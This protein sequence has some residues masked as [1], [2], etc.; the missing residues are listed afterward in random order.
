MVL[1]SHIISMPKSQEQT[2][3]HQAII[4]FRINHSLYVPSFFNQLVIWPHKL[5]FCPIPISLSL[6]KGIDVPFGQPHVERFPFSSCLRIACHH[7]ILICFYPQIH[8]ALL[9]LWFSMCWCC[10]PQHSKISG[11]SITATSEVSVFTVGWASVGRG[12]GVLKTYVHVLRPNI[13]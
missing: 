8:C 13:S 6:L 11:I 9:C 4:S 7:L 1:C 3:L 10:I 5:G 12:E 2:S